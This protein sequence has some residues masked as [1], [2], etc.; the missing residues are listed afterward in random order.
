MNLLEYNRTIVDKMMAREEDRP[1]LVQWADSNPDKW[2]DRVRDVDQ[3]TMAKALKS[4]DAWRDLWTQVGE[5]IEEDYEE[6]TKVPPDKP[7]P[8]TE[9]TA[10]IRAL[11]EENR[12]AHG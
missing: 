11:N 10:Q 7:E 5:K 12:R 3:K 9:Q 6:D 8:D 4:R 1:T 2:I